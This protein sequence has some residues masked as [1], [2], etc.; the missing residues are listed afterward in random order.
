MFYKP[1][2]Q[3]NGLDFFL[4]CYYLLRENG[5]AEN[6]FLYSSMNYNCSCDFTDFSLR[7]ANDIL[8]TL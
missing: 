3:I 7:L 6:D 1:A 4:T 8:G 2:E 5:Y